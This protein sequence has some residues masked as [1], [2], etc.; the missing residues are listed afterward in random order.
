MKPV[1]AK[2]NGRWCTVYESKKYQDVYYVG[3][4]VKFDGSEKLQTLTIK[5]DKDH[6]V[7]LGYSIDGGSDVVCDKLSWA[8]ALLQAAAI[9][10]SYS[11]DQPKE[12]ELHTEEN[13]YYYALTAAS[14]AVMWQNYRESIARHSRGSFFT[15]D[16]AIAQPIIQSG[17]KFP[18]D[19]P[20]LE[21]ASSCYQ[22]S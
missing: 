2:E 3:F 16:I 17:P 10:D 7:A 18:N 13:K 6:S 8:N 4:R 11:S 22:S 5:T 20:Q 21:S 9:Q 19:M 14:Q 1:F 15:P 12:F